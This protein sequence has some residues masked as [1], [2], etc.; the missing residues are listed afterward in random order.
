MLEVDPIT[1]PEVLKS[2]SQI[3]MYKSSGMV[4]VSSR[5]LKDFLTLAVCEVT[6]LGNDVIALG[7]FPDKWKITTVTPIPKVPNAENPTDLRP[8]SLLP[9]PGKLIG[10]HL[11]N[12]LEGKKHLTCKQFGFRKEKST[13][14]AL[15]SFLDDISNG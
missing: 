3:S 15:A 13:A 2:I 9:I 6:I 14:G 1:A 12:F 5:V 8:I 7:I 4:D 10:K 11:T